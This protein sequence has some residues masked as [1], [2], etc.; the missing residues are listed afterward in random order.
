M[1]VLAALGEFAR[2]AAMGDCRPLAGLFGGDAAIAG[3]VIGGLVDGV[4]N[5]LAR[6]PLGQLPLRHARRKTSHTLLLARDG[7]ASLA[8]T[9]YDGVALAAQPTPH[10]AEFAPI[11]TWV[12]VLAGTGTAERVTRDTEY[13]APL[14]RAEVDLRPGVML[15]RD[16]WC[17]GLQ[18]RAVDG[19]LVVLR[20]QRQLR[21]PDTVHEFRLEDGALLHR[22]A[23]RSEDSRLE[24]AIAVLVAQGRRDAVPALARIVTGS[25]PV[26]LRWSALRAVLGLDTRA[27]LVLLG[28]LAGGEDEVLGAAARGLQRDLID[29]WPELE[30]VAQWRG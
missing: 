20:L 19:A 7:T 1:P 28:E 12:R 9:V 24:L 30:K 27:G 25:A 26:S 16:G 18:M 4:V 11:E 15:K 2:G 6:S 8:I 21:V 13:L 29:E 5:G 14:Q 23:A 17:E 22:A 3:D 10:S